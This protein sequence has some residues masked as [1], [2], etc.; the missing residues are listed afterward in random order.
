MR[1]RIM[2]GLLIAICGLSGIIIF[3]TPAA[4]TCLSPWD[5]QSIRA[6]GTF[7]TCGGDDSA[8]RVPLLN[9][10]VFGGITYNDVYAT[11]NSTVTFGREDANFWDF[12]YTPSISFQAYDWVEAFPGGFWNGNDNQEYFNITTTNSGFVIDLS[13]RR[14][15]HEGDL[16]HNVLA[17]G[18][19]PDGT[20]Q[21]QS[22]TSSSNQNYRN[23]C[24]LTE[25]AAPVDFDTCGVT[26]QVS[27][28]AITALVEQI[29]AND[30]PPEVAPEIVYE[31]SPDPAQQSRTDAISGIAG[32]DGTQEEVSVNGNFIE[33]VVAI[34]VNNA[35]ITPGSWSQTPTSVTFLAPKS[36]N[37]VYEVQVYN[38]SAPV[39]DS[40]SFT[41]IG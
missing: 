18:R 30:V 40:Q 12:P 13:G 25:G 39:V 4:A 32:S 2:A 27:L 7:E 17:F 8:Y 34:T 1:I 5:I 19:N 36:K 9:P 29:V 15:P 24:V 31:P 16:I 35:K 14:F 41:L 38:G 33:N 26:P 21:I 10:V 20:L 22:F 23:G 28:M 11:T 6:E 3:P 37:G